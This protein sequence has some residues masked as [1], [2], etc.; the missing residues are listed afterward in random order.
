MSA[1]MDRNKDGPPM[2]MPPWLRARP[3]AV[4]EELNF[5]GP[6]PSA[7]KPT[8]AMPRTSNIEWPPAPKSLRSANDRVAEF[9]PLR[10][11][12]PEIVPEPR[13]LVRPRK[14]ARSLLQISL[15]LWL[16]AMVCYGIV[17]MTLTG[18]QRAV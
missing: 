13:E 18:G 1:P 6:P 4:Q 10:S 3:E 15:I 14:R 9:R 8:P 5:E 11:L 12:E 7:R 17:E 16:V 2:A